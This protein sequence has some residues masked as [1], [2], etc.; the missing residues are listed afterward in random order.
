MSI[1][2]AILSL[3]TT[4][5]VDVQHWTVYHMERASGKKKAAILILLVEYTMTII[6]ELCDPPVV[7]HWY[8]VE[9]GLIK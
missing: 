9:D 8:F 4:I 3:M 1:Y 5:G 6:Y 7:N 2:E